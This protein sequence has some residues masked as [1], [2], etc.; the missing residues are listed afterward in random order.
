MCGSFGISNIGRYHCHYPSNIEP[1]RFIQFNKVRPNNPNM[2]IIFIL[3]NF[4]T[5]AHSL[6]YSDKIFNGQ[7]RISTEYK[8]GIWKTWKKL[9]YRI[10][11]KV[12]KF[13]L[14]F[15]IRIQ[16]RDVE[17][18]N[19]NVAFMSADW[20]NLITYGYIHND[21]TVDISKCGTMIASF[22]VAS[23]KKIISKSKF[24]QV[25]STFQW[26]RF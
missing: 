21:S 18:I 7:M 3:G 24:I 9:T 14:I 4:L 13:S 10:L 8:H 19:F 2:F 25:E 20:R 5:W 11:H 15:F 17:N 1:Q 26:I 22:E 16:V 12:R 6:I 23:S